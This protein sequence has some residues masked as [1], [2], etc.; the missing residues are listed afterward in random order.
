MLIT[1]LYSKKTFSGV[2]LNFCSFL[3]MDCKGLIHN[4]IFRA[5]NIC[6]NYTTLHNEIDFSKSIWQKSSFSLF[7]I[8]NCIKHFLDKEFIKRN[9]SDAVSR[10][11]EVLISLEF[12]GKFSLQVKDSQLKFF[13]LVKKI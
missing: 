1:S 6:A 11:K 4:L 5:Y 12:L 7:F 3:P 9:V 10:K 13:L 8:D 2:Y